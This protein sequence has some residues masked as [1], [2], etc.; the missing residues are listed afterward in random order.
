MEYDGFFDLN[1][2]ADCSNI[3]ELSQIW[4][5]RDYRT[6]AINQVVDLTVDLPKRTKKGEKQVIFIPEPL[7]CKLPPQYAGKMKVLN[8]LTIKISDISHFSKVFQGKS[9]AVKKYHIVAVVPDNLPCFQQAININEVDIIA[10]D[11]RTKPLWRLTKKH[12]NLVIEQNKFFEVCYSPAIRDSST[13]NNTIFISQLLYT[14]GKAKNVILSSETSEASFLRTP[15]EV[16]YLSLIFGLNENKAR[17]CLSAEPS[18]V[19]S[20]ALKRQ[21]GKSSFTVEHV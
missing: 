21:M 16:M 6:I 14:I 2:L 4:F 15:Y 1:V 8:R 18:N 10:V 20:R 11:C 9:S 19:I 7:S 5:E 3:E 12:Y 17:H 13:F